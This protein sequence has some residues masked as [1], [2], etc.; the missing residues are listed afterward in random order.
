MA[1]R[2]VERRQE[3]KVIYG[4]WPMVFFGENLLEGPAQASF[5]KITGNSVMAVM[6]ASH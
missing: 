1:L 3:D 6:K 5:F 4:D 2:P